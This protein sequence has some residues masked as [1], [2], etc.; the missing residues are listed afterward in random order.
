MYVYNGQNQYFKALAVLS[1]SAQQSI[2]LHF[3]VSST[4]TTF[5][6]PSVSQSRPAAVKVTVGAFGE[7]LTTIQR[8]EVGGASGGQGITVVS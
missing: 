3:S 5:A 6:P 1:N 4:A 2:P 7:N 8:K